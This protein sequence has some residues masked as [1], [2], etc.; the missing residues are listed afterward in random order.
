[1]NKILPLFIQAVTRRG[2][3]R[4]LPM[5]KLLMGDENKLEA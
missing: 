2:R 3:V 1:M 5:N 4:L